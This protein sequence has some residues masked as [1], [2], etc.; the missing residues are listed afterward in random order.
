MADPC[1][2][3]RKDSLDWRSHNC[4]F[5]SDPIDRGWRCWFASAEYGSGNVRHPTFYI[6][7]S[8]LSYRAEHE[9]GIRQVVTRPSN[10]ELVADHRSICVCACVLPLVV[11]KNQSAPRAYTQ[12]LLAPVQLDRKPE[13]LLGQEFRLE[14]QRGRG[15]FLNGQ[16]SS[17]LVILSCI[18]MSENPRVSC[19]R[20]EKDITW[21]FLILSLE[22]TVNSARRI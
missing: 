4:P 8:P 18:P 20:C 15:T 3:R 5:S 6:S 7:L 1:G 21:T 19:G 11:E 14:K 13:R 2:I 17:T 22:G 16:S 12:D 10:P 9:G